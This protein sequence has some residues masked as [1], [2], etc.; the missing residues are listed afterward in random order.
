MVHTLGNC[1][2]GS[3]KLIYENVLQAAIEDKTFVNDPWGVYK[4]MKARLLQF[5]GTLGEKQ[6]RVRAEWTELKNKPNE[7]LLEFEAH[8]EHAH[9]NMVQ[10]GLARTPAEDYVDYLEKV[11]EAHSKIIRF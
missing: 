7:T 6:I 1:L 9:R 10:A 4:K 2:K 5:T 11:G 8:R 3:R